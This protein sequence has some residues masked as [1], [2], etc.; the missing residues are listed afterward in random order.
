[1]LSTFAWFPVALALLCVAII[2]VDLAW[3]H[4]QHMWI[5]N[6]VWPLTEA[7][8]ADTLSLLAWQMGMYG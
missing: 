7:A 1:M 5:M 4:R 6:L 2:V 3:G 8:K